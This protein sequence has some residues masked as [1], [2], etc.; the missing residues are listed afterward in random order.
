MPGAQEPASTHIP[1]HLPVALPA[2]LGLARP[3]RGR[4]ESSAAESDQRLAG[5]PSFPVRVSERVLFG[6]ALHFG[7]TP[8]MARILEINALQEVTKAR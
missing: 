3:P 4:K 7:S 6:T 5:T 8:Q 1:S 2:H